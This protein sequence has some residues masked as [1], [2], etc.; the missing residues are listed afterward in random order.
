[1]S[2]MNSVPNADTPTLA[3][4]IVSYNSASFLPICLE[5][6][7]AEIVTYPS[8][9]T[10]LKL[11]VVENGS[12]LASQVVCQSLDVD[13][14]AAPANLGYAG[15]ANFGWQSLGHADIYLVLNPDMRF[16]SGWL[17]NMIAPF[18]RD[19]QIGVVGCKLL[20][21]DNKIQHAGGLIIHGTALGLHFGAGEP[22]DGR[23]DEGSAVEFVTGAALAIRADLHQQ[24]GGFDEH[25][26]P[27]YYEDVDLCARVRQLG[28]KVWYEPQAVAYHY[29]GGTF[30]RGAGYYRAF[31]RNRLRF[32]LKNF[33][34]TRLLYDF[35][36]AERS[37]LKG[38]L[39]AP[40][41]RASEAIYKAARGI[42]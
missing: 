16:C 40:D 13:W 42:K 27:G 15:G 32:A 26:F 17:L 33:S 10:K 23:W 4:V 29:E 19:S 6:L 5:S 1:M 8:Y 7:L 25:F 20:D 18:G 37:R 2:Y 39:E 35:V 38:M 22:D 14:L 31:H 30:G 28:F 9:T 36:P 21:A 24:L 34:T 3:L 12:D 41:R 11:V